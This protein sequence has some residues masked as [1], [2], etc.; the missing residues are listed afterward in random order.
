[1]SKAAKDK[2]ILNRIIDE[3]SSLSYHAYPN[4]FSFNNF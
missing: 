4:I 2:L 1:M 3:F